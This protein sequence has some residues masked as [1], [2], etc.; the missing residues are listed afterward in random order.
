MIQGVL[1]FLW[2]DPE[3]AR[4]HRVTWTRIGSRETLL[5]LEVW[6]RV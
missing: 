5:V 6:V 3:H 2:V 1:S 4:D